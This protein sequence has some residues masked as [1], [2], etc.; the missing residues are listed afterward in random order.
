M[1]PNDRKNLSIR[2]QRLVLP[3]YAARTGALPTARRR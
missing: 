3:V 2:Q 1:V